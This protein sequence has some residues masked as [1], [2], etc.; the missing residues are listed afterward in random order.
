MSKEILF[1]KT[2][3]ELQEIV[4]N[5]ELPGFTASQ[6][7]DWLYKKKI[8]SIDEMSN[9]SKA[10]REKLNSSFI[11]GLLPLAPVHPWYPAQ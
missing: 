7:T 2:P 3:E 11:L 9:L 8:S 6:I 10:V 4:K 1:G 5:L